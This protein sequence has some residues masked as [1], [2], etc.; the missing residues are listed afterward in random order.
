M[1]STQKSLV[2]CM[3]SLTQKL[4]PGVVINWRRIGDAPPSGNGARDSPAPVPM[5]IDQPI[6][7]GNVSN[8]LMKMESVE[9]NLKNTLMPA[10]CEKFHHE[11]H[12][13]PLYGIIARVLRKCQQ[14]CFDVY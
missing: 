11:I 8:I 12:V 1:V 3:E 9:K 10:I 4:H 5:E 7:E 6:E 14:L 13:C 2:Q